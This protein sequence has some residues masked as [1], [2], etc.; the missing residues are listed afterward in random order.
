V[1]GFGGPGAIG[2]TV[3]TGLSVG[4]ELVGVLPD[5]CVDLGESE[6]IAKFLLVVGVFT[7]ACAT[8]FLRLAAFL[9]REVPTG[10]ALPLPRFRFLITSVFKLSGRTTPCNLRKRPQALQRGCPSGL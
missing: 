1:I 9:E 5:D 4:P 2:T 7:F 6:S 3:L 8:E 10:M